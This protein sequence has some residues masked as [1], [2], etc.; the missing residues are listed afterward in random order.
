MIELYIFNQF[1]VLFDAK[2]GQTVT[3]GVINMGPCWH[4]LPTL[5]QQGALP[6]PPEMSC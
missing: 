5:F 6:C 4:N 2:N 3:F 1:I